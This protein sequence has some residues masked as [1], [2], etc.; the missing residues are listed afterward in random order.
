MYDV[1]Q[2]ADS[3]HR[4]VGRPRRG[5]E[6]ERIDALINAATHVFLRDGYGLASIDKVAGEAGVSTRT[7]YERFKNKADLLGAV[8]RRLV[9][10]MATVVASAD[11]EGLEARAAL[12][13]IARTMTDR[14]RDP[15]SAALFRIVATEAHRFPELAAQMRENDKR[16]VDAALAAYLRRE[17]NRGTLVLKDPDKAAALFL[18]MVFSELHERWLFGNEQTLTELDLTSHLHYVVDLFLLGA[19]PRPGQQAPAP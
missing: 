7:I 5:T 14:A 3:P 16:C 11:L 10:R 8:I 1:R 15:D 6:G 17:I 13:L 12:M 4:K 9:D 19:A 18:Q 2:T